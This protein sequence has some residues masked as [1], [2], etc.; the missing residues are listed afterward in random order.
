[1]LWSLFSQ[2]PASTTR[3][4]PL[5]SES[6]RFFLPSSRCGLCR[7]RRGSGHGTDCSIGAAGSAR[8][9]AAPSPQ[10]SIQ[11]SMRGRAPAGASSALAPPWG[12]AGR[13]SGGPMAPSSCT[14]LRGGS[15]TAT[16]PL[17]VRFRPCRIL[18][19]PLIFPVLPYDRPRRPVR[20]GRG[21]RRDR[22]DRR[23][24]AGSV[25]VAVMAAVMVAWCS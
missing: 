11:P 17:P 7:R 22:E 1:M 10:P 18:L 19:V 23:C 16:P 13:G 6:K 14:I 20:A 24:S 9:A 15:R 4:Q 21:N 25:M 3:Q 12:P 5:A 8:R 2:P